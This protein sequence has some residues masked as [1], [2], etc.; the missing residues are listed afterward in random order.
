M[1][2]DSLGWVL[3]VA[4]FAA[5]FTT[6]KSAD[7][8]ERAPPIA[9]EIRADLASIEENLASFC[10]SRCGTVTLDQDPR[11]AYAG[12]AAFLSP[13]RSELGFNH[14]YLQ[15]QRARFGKAAVYFVI[16]HEYG[17]HLARTSSDPL[18][19]ELGADALAGCALSRAGLDIGAAS[20]AI[21][22]DH[23]EEIV[24]A[25]FREPNRPENIVKAAT[26][27]SHPP[28]LERLSAPREGA[29]LCQS[30]DRPLTAFLGA[31]SKA[32]NLDVSGRQ[33]VARAATEAVALAPAAR[34]EQSVWWQVKTCFAAG[35]QALKLELP[36]LRPRGR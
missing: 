21:R 20:S 26:P 19:D 22:R 25:V 15:K 24:A 10:G 32:A 30:G 31:L 2:R 28:W 13:D 18:Q 6:S 8:T 34:P 14:L 23:F 27:R 4:C 1:L 36:S 7:A 12:Q 35:C 16:A 33:P 29:A 5:L 17:H 9:V 3:T 11:A